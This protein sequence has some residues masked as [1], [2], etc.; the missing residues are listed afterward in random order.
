MT[1]YTKMDGPTLLR[2]MGLDGM[3]WTEAFRQIN[4][5]CSISDDVMLGWFCNAIMNTLDIERGTIHN[6]DHAQ[7]LLDNNLP[8]FNVEH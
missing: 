3:K 7:Y 8:P 6:G 1:D 5:E 2:E 4:P